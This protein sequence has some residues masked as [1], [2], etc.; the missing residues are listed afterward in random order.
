MNKRINYEAAKANNLV[1]RK[2]QDAR[3]RKGVSQEELSDMLSSAGIPVR[4][5]AISKWE[6]GATIPSS[7][8]L[9]A[10]C[11]VLDIPSG[12]EFFTDRLREGAS[13]SDEFS[14]DLNYAGQRKLQAYRDDLIA[15][16]RYSRKGH[17]RRSVEIIE[18]PVSLLQASAGT[19]DYLDEEN[20]ETRRFPKNTVPEGADFGVY[21]D[22]NS[23]EPTYING[24]LVWV[25]ISHELTPGEVGLFI[26]DGKSFIK[27]YDE[28]TP[29]SDVIDGFTDSYGYVHPQPVLVSYNDD[30]KP[31]VISPEMSFSI[32]GRVLN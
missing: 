10:I 7:Y 20:F 24:Q 4:Q 5:G 26:V 12:F 8:Q 25:R 14:D 6:K 13:L 21:V 32:I 31:R 30:Y 19:G 9:L 28:Q 3:I 16:G 15:S 27:V 1:G 17:P 22:G 2:I 23:M 29:A 11:D 18:M